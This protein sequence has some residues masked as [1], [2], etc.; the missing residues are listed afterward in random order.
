MIKTLLT[1]LIISIS[2]LAH[3]QYCITGGPSSSSVISVVDWYGNSEDT[4][5]PS[6]DIT[7]KWVWI[8]LLNYGEILGVYTVIQIASAWWSFAV[9]I[10]DLNVCY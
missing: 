10:V 8:F 7:K 4:S 5:S 6:Y 9:L 3:S 2:L 1:T